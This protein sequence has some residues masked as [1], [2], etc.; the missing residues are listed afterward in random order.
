M[1]DTEKDNGNDTGIGGEVPA[2]DAASTLATASPE[3]AEDKLARIKRELTAVPTLPGVYLWKNAQGEVIYVGK[4]KQ[5]RARMRQYV[6]F[7]DDRAKIPLLVDQIHSFDYIVVESEHESLVLEKNLINQHSP[8]FN[9]DFKDDKSYPFIA[10]TKGDVFPAIKYTREKHKPNTRYFGPYTDSRAARAMVD[11]ARKVV[12]LCSASCADWRRLQRQLAKSDLRTFLSETGTRPCFDA[13]VGLGPGACCGKITP[14]SYAENVRRVERFLAGHHREFVT[15][16][17]DE[18]QS[19]AAELDFERAARLKQRIDTIN[20]LASRQHA[21]SAHNL[22][23]DVIGFFREETVA[24][25]HVFMVREGR[26]VNSNEFVLNRGTDVPDVD[27]QHNFLLRYYDAT[28]SIPHEVIVRDL[29]EDASAMQVWLTDKLASPHGAK[30]R[31]TA[32]QRGEKAELITMAETNAKHTLARYKVRTN[33][34]DTRINN[35]LLQLESALA[36]DAPPMRIECFDISTI[37]G[38]YTVASMVVFTNGKPDKNQYRRFKIKTPLDEANDFLSMQEVMSRRYAPERMADE[39]FGKKPDL[40][41]LDGG[42]P[43]LSAVMDMFDR[44]GVRDIALAGLA[45][46]EEEL[47][48]PWQDTGPVVLPGGS[49]SLYLVKQ[50]RDEAHRFAI[51]YHRELRGKGMTASILDEVAGLGPVRKKALMKHFKSFRNLKAASLDDILAAR[52]LPAEVAEELYRVLAQYNEKSKG[53]TSGKRNGDNSR[54]RNGENEGKN[55]AR[56]A[57]VGQGTSR[58]DYAVVSTGEKSED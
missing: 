17:T 45:K 36:L 56:S 40:I 39:R 22:D 25:V 54:E 1:R 26:I 33:Y 49:A 52:V 34:D 50:V 2:P 7:Q 53:E 6:N 24:G 15:E 47:F 19:A 37:H 23:A 8:F 38:S 42:K 44:M 46:R 32:P 57:P 48:V 12:P 51:T 31:F 4:A 16:L 3:S 35:A 14:E 43:Q 20:G 58:I 30:V 9:A 55:A 28:T 18:M 21:V 29:P 10:L 27:L 11:I 13:H 41:I 5:L